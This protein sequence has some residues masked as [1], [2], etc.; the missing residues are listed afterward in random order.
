MRT[1]DGGYLWQ[2][3]TPP[4][5]AEELDFR[6]V[7]GF[8]ANTAL[9]MSSGKGA[10]SRVYKTTDGCSTWQLVLEN[11]DA[12]GFFDALVFERE[13]AGL[14]KRGYLLGD[15]VGGSFVL[16]ATVDGG[17]HWTRSRADGLKVAAAGQGAF[18][19]SNSAL[20]AEGPMF[21]T[22]GPGGPYVYAGAAGF[23][24]TRV[25]IRGG[26]A[27]EGVFSLASAGARVVAVGGDYSK[28]DERMGT[29]AYS[30]D[31]GQ[32]W[33]AAETMPGGYRSAVAYDAEAK[34]WLAVGPS[35]ADVSYDDGRTWTALKGAGGWNAVSLPFA[36]GAKGKIGHL[37]PGG[38]KQAR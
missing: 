10:A 20:T 12:D 5:G 4:K 19:A 30:E 14:G 11:P 36:V 25:P 28:P 34:A 22:S 31:G 1:E 35:G 6:G 29:A 7:Q 2:R 13:A 33:K 26:T 8:D 27:S 3:C 18:A 32:S 16:Y 15:P 17:T 37:W 23:R 24:A 21:G 9:V 38:L